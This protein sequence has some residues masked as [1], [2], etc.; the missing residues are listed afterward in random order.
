MLRRMKTLDLGFTLTW[1]GHSAFLLGTPAGQHVLVDPFLTGNPTTPAGFVLPALDLIL[2]THGHGDHLGDTVELAKQHDCP[3]F[4]GFELGEWLLA[5]GVARA[6]GMGKGGTQ[7]AAG[8]AVTGTNAIHSS[9]IDMAGGAYAGEPMGFVIALENGVRVYHAG[10]T[11]PMMDMQLIREL[12][13]PDV[14]ILPI[15]DLYTMGPREA[16]WAAQ[17]LGARFVVP[18]HFGTFDVLSGTPDALRREMA[19]RGVRATV[20]DLQPGVTVA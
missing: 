17:Q 5:Q 12:Y 8:V 11:G 18:M 3:V 9:S 6:S 16:A 10:D 15:G 7:R 4:C 2:L 13:A 19:A 14:A 1:L 20:I